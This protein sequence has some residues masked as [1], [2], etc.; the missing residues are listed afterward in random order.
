MSEQ[1]HTEWTD[2]PVCPHCGAIQ[3]DAWEWGQDECGETDCGS[4]EKP[5]SYTQHI[6]VNWTTRKLTPTSEEESK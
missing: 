1:H 6:S 2:E 3:G 4:C 5:F